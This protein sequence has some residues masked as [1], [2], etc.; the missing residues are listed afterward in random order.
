MVYNIIVGRD[1]SDRKKFGDKGVL[2]LGKSYVK[3][4][5][6]TSLSNNIF[7]DVVRSHVILVAGKRGSGKCLH[8][9]TL[10]TLENGNAAPIK[11]L[12]KNTQ[13]VLGLDNKL[14][15]RE[16]KKEGFYKRRV[17]RLLKI[18]LRSGKEIKLTPEH[19]LLTIKGWKPVKELTINSRIATPR[20]IPC[21][22][23]DDMEDC[24]IK[25]LAYLI[26]EGHTKKGVLFSNSDKKIVNEFSESLNT[27]DSKLKLKK[28]K[29]DHY[30]IVE[31]GYRTVCTAQEDIKRDCKGRFARGSR[32][33][34]KKR[35]IREFL[36]KEGIHGLKSQYKFIPESIMLLKKEKLSL[37]LNRLFSCDGSIYHQNG[38]EIS[39]ASSSEKLIRQVQHL[40]LRFEVLSKL[41]NKKIK[42]NGKMF[43]SFE[44]V[45]NGK[46]VFRFVK[47]IG[48]YGKKEQKQRKCLE[49]TM[50][51]T[52]NPNVDTIPK[53]IWGLYRPN[54]WAEIGK[55]FGY[56]TPKALRSSIG[57]APSR[58]KL[59]GIAK[60]D[61]NE[62]MYLLAT[63][64]IFWD[65]IVGIEEL[66]GDFTVY[67]IGVPEMHN[68]IANDII[69]HNSWSLGVI[70]EG[71][72]HLQKEIADNMSVIIFD[73]MGIFWTMKYPNEKE[74]RLL[75]DWDMKPEGL[76][77]KIYTPKG[78][79]QKYKDEGIPTDYSFSIKPSDLTAED[80]I[81]TFEL[82][83]NDPVA[84]AI[85]KT[86]YD[87][88]EKGKTEYDIDDIVKAI[89][90]DKEL[91]INTK[92][93]AKNRF[94]AAKGWGLFD[95]EGTKMSEISQAGKVSVLDV[96]CYTGSGGWGVKS[97]VIGLITKR[98]FLERMGARKTE[99]IKMISGGYSYVGG[100]DEEE[101]DKK[102]MVWLLLDEA[103]EFLP[104]VGK[105]AATD[106][107]V[108]V[109]REGRQPGVSL[110]LATQQPGKIHKDVMTQ[111]DL[112]LSHRI[113]ARPDV[114]ALNE[115][116]QS[117]QTEDLLTHLNNLPREAGA[118]IILDDNSE[119]IYPIRVRPRFTWHGGEAPTAITHKKRLELGLT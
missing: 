92:N 94:R 4:G 111:S 73:T 78:Y 113:T 7:I 83:Q 14:R 119:R 86:L 3:M 52:R 58:Q 84:I 102:P 72:A 65:E 114:E 43:D 54:N 91:D 98:L 66:E 45:I 17:D 61:Q 107:L 41:R 6:T 57:Y 19:P 71:I 104:D 90:S 105:T 51:I 76:D 62:A 55:T 25:L 77:I 110:I 68:F 75:K 56:T 64:D 33:S 38:W 12:E 81:L 80:W 87:F 70:A 42:L 39:Y 49:E 11:D 29:K 93:S 23:N 99:E 21:F 34:C 112:I 95:M 30:S 89:D 28:E 67:D 88:Q 20:N 60:A 36:E 35:S 5:R 2:F 24:K 63:S 50:W 32:I 1:E 69:V 100:Y 106:A 22:G 109:L 26:A 18:K 48:F 10:I 79:Y 46:N 13:K 27:F 59:M 101:K 82:N 44:L 103:H 118:G 31:K 108:T 74:R 47:E 96:S 115:M 15:I 116:M 9:D 53:E 16:L 97:L 37:F 85:E 117:Y 8:E 40:L